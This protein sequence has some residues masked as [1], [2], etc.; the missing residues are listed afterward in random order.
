MESLLYAAAYMTAMQLL[1]ASARC[2]RPS[3]L[4]VSTCLVCCNHK[5]AML[6]L[7]ANMLVGQRCLLP[8][9]LH[10][11]TSPRVDR[12]HWLLP[13][14]HHTHAAEHDSI[15]RQQNVTP[16]SPATSQLL[17]KTSRH[18]LEPYRRVNIR[19]EGPQSHPV[20]A[21]SCPYAPPRSQTGQTCPR[22]AAAAHTCIP[23]GRC[24]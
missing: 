7:A 1:S 4:Q 12:P 13:L 10:V 19:V 3:A 2:W 22:R 17:G 6:L 5:T 9:A 16:C 8:F 21:V 14:Q 23:A 18:S 20:S 24:A 15:A 11:H